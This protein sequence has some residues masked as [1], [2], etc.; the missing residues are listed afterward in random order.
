MGIRWYLSKIK[1]N[2]SLCWDLQL[3]VNLDNLRKSTSLVSR[4][5]S[6]KR[7]PLHHG[8][9]SNPCFCCPALLHPSLIST[10]C[11]PSLQG[12]AHCWCCGLLS[13]VWLLG[14]PGT[15]AHHAPLSMGFSRP[16]YWSGLPFP[17]PGDLPDLGTELTPLAWQVDS[18]PMSYLGSLTSN[19]YNIHKKI[20]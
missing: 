1:P 6:L 13:Y 9:T 7:H 18:L 8:G 16:E 4:G 20:V 2:N 15:T 10:T 3:A 17:F 5:L 12:L 14:T 11:S 19:I